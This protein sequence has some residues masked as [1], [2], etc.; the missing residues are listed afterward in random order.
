MIFIIGHIKPYKDN[1]ANFM[2]LANEM[3]VLICTYAMYTFTEFLPYLENRQL[4]GKILV[5]LTI[6]N[7][8]LNIFVA[9]RQNLFT[10]L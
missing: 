1:V 8:A 5:Y 10:I 4:V 6:S 7:V 9:V 2:E 3:F